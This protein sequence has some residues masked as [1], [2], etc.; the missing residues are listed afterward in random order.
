[1]GERGRRRC[2][3]NC[4]RASP[5]AHYRITPAVGGRR[6]A[7]SA[8]LFGCRAKLEFACLAALLPRIAF[9]PLLALLALA[10]ALGSPGPVRLR[11]PGW[12]SCRNRGT[13][14]RAS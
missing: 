13:C 7:R 6:L 10:V 4:S 8:L 2:E 5:T 9:S 12:G 3:Q 14:C 1:M 11:Q